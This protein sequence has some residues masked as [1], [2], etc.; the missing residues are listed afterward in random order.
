MLTECL[1]LI[2]APDC[3]VDRFDSFLK[4]AKISQ[5]PDEIWQKIA[6]QLR[7]E[8][9]PFGQLRILQQEWRQYEI[10]RLDPT[11]ESLHESRRR[12]EKMCREALEAHANSSLSD[13]TQVVTDMAINQGVAE[14]FKY[15]KA[16]VLWGLN[17]ETTVPE[18]A[19]KPAEEE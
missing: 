5:S 14:K 6:E 17:E 10:D 3:R 11:N 16:M 4:C 7:A 19:P 2:P 1:F 12:V 8:G 9:L 13:L 18:T 15:L